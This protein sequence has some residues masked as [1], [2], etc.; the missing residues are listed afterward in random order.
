MNFRATLSNVT[1]RRYAAALA[2]ERAAFVALTLLALGF[3][4]EWVQPLVGLARP[5]GLWLAVLVAPLVTASDY[6]LEAI[7]FLSRVATDVLVGWAT[8]DLAR[9]PARLHNLARAM[10]LAGPVVG[11]LGLAEVAHIEPFVQWLAGFKE[12]PTYFGDFIR[13]SATLNSLGQ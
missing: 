12:S 9:T 4:F 13:L 10:A 5:M 8:Y 7:K 11:G 1:R 6:H 3:A 2:F